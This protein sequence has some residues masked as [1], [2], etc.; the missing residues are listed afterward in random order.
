MKTCIGLYD[1]PIITLNIKDRDK[2]EALR[3]WFWFK[4]FGRCPICHTRLISTRYIGMIRIR[5][6]EYVCNCGWCKDD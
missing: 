4:V 1:K 2:P 6:I 3:K 5:T